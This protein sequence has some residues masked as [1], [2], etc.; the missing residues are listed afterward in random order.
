MSQASNQQ[1]DGGGGINVLNVRVP[2]ITTPTTS[3][4]DKLTAVRRFLDETGVLSL[5]S[6]VRR[7]L[8]QT[9]VL[10]LGEPSMTMAEI[11]AFVRGRLVL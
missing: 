1:Y 5:F 7:F 10:S 11:G 4:S 8:E 9:G 2:I 3:K 6:A